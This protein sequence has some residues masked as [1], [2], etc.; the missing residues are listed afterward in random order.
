MKCSLCCVMTFWILAT[1][2]FWLLLVNNTAIWTTDW[3]QV[4]FSVFLGIAY[5]AVFTTMLTFFLQQ[6]GTLRIGPTRA[7]SYNYLNPALVVA[8]EWVTGRGLPPLM[9]LPGVA[10]VLL[11]TLV[12]Q[13]GV[14]EKRADRQSLT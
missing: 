14:K 7:T 3:G 6:H 11:A 10:I 12:L 9:A 2:A 5:L 8:L 13:L 1:G 4:D